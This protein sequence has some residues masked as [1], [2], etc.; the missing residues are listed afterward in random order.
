[1]LKNT[2]RLQVKPKI[3]Y[4]MFSRVSEKI[5]ETSKTKGE[6]KIYMAIQ[7]KERHSNITQNR[8]QA[9]SNKKG[10]C[11]IYSFNKYLL[12][13]ILCQVWC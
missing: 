13:A 11:F 6:L 3:D 4:M 2:L 5:H 1:M 8:I 7:T 9:K 12:S 10:G